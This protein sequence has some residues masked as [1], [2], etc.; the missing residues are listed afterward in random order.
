MQPELHGMLPVSEGSFQALQQDAVH[1]P[2]SLKQSAAVCNSLNFVN[3][4]QLVGDAADFK[5]FRLCEARFSVRTQYYTALW[6]PLFL[7]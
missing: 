4:T 7:I 5:A 2:N 6:C 1:W 3:K